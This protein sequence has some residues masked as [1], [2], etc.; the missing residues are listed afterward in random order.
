MTGMGQIGSGIRI[1]GNSGCDNCFLVCYLKT[2]VMLF[3]FV[4]RKEG[5]YGFIIIIIN[6]VEV[7]END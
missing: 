7:I 4:S 6:G 5:D 1:I 3:F 2:L